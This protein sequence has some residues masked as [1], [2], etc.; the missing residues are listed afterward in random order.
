MD[1]IGKSGRSN[2]IDLFT[3]KPDIQYGSVFSVHGRFSLYNSTDR[4]ANRNSVEAG[5]GMT[6]LL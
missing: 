2:W 6:D 4:F 3:G 5:A 1:I